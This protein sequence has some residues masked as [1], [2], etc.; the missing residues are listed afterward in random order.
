MV[1]YNF[2]SAHGFL[3]SCWI[4]KLNH[5]L[6][7]RRFMAAS[8]A[9]MTEKRTYPEKSHRSGPLRLSLVVSTGQLGG[10]VMLS[11]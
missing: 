5:N 2:W 11:R 8:G 6:T 3:Y 10:P 4:H 9:P 7:E 1:V